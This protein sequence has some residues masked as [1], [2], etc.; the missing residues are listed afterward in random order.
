MTTAD[1]DTRLFLQVIDLT[2]P[3]VAAQPPRARQR[4]DNAAAQNSVQVVGIQ[5][6]G[7]VVARIQGVAAAGQPGAVPRVGWAQAAPPHL[8]PVPFQYA[9][10]HVAPPQ[11]QAGPSRATA[12]AAKSPEKAPGDDDSTDAAKCALCLDGL[13]EDL[14]IN[15]GCGHVFHYSC[16]KASLARFKHC[17]RCRKKINGEKALK[18][19]YM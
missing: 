2:D 17:P 18:R 19:I 3:S 5:R 10:Q 12:A 7:A 11:A 4:A 13:K 8:P 6:G 9:Q 16:M 1:T 15:P 14:C